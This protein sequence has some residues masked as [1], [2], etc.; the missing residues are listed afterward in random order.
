MSKLHEALASGQFVV[1][2]EVGPPKGTH[3]ETMMEDAEHLRG[4]V[5]AINVTDIQSSVMR[6]SSLA[7]CIKLKQAGLE[8]ILQM[9][10][11]DRNRLALQSDLLGAAVH[12]IDTVLA[13]T[14]DHVQLG[15]HPQAQGVFDLD[16]VGLLDAIKT[17]ES[18]K[19]LAGE[20]LDGTPKFFKGAVVAPCSDPV[21]TQLLKMEK[22][23]AAGAQF[24]QTQAVYDPKPFESFMK[25]AEQFG[26]PVLVGIVLLK[27]PGMAKFMNANVAGVTVP[28]ALIKELADTDKKERK[29]KSV[30]IAARLIREM[31]SMCQGAHIMPLGWDKLVPDVLEQ[32]EVA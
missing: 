11:R 31:K 19:D 9:V 30:E 5:A 15:D 4:K 18:G 10:C 14:G 28:K 1:T 13:L 26:V 2:G 16:S 7:V 6:L 23:V 20:E 8:P 12:G 3:I 27:T 32:A 21:E 24:F 25:T 29:K 17:L 22:K